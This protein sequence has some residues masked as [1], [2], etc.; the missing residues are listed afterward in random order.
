MQH[1]FE[2]CIKGCALRKE[3]QSAGSSAVLSRAY[4]LPSCLLYLPCEVSELCNH[5]PHLAID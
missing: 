1:L 5:S 3:S 2:P 4:L